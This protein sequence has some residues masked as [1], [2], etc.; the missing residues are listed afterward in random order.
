MIITFVIPTLNEAEH[1]ERCVRSINQLARPAEIDEVEIVVVDTGSTD[2]TR[3]IARAIATRVLD[4][5]GGTVASARNIGA[6]GAR[7]DILA[8][9]DADCELPAEWLRYGIEHLQR[10]DVAAMGTSLAAPH[11]HATWVERHWYGVTYG[12]RR[13]AYGFVRWLPTSNLLVWRH[14]F[15]AVHGFTETLV[16][17]EDSDL[18]YRLARVHTLVEENRVK[19]RHLRESRTVRELFRREWWRGL[20]NFQSWKLHGCDRRECWSVVAP[21][22]FVALMVAIVLTAIVAPGPQKPLLLTI[23]TLAMSVVPFLMLLKKGVHPR[24]GI[25]SFV[26]GYVLAWVYLSARGI[27]LIDHRRAVEPVGVTKV[28]CQSRI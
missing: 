7:G 20:G 17:C 14:A 3:A 4:A 6:H 9:V 26:C 10:P 22:A 16:T 18:G 5:R 1:L 19:T 23:E 13:E 25:S 24:V 21:F 12:T 15:D 11:P 28:E 2:Q 8:F 27:A